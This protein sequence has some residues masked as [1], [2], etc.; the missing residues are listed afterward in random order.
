MTA[1]LLL[2]VALSTGA[3]AKPTPT[4]FITGGDD[5]SA[6]AGDSHQALRYHLRRT[7]NRIDAHSLVCSLATCDM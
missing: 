7:R 1:R 5:V 3:C 4:Q 6:E 2:A